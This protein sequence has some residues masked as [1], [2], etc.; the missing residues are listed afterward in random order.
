MPR[1]VREYAF[2]GTGKTL[3]EVQKWAEGAA[4]AEEEISSCPKLLRQW[5]AEREELKDDVVSRD[6]FLVD[7]PK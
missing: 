1:D 4:E 5:A 7:F 6:V 3:A 2:I